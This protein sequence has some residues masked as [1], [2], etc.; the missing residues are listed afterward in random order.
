MAYP[1]EEDF[2]SGIP[3]GFASKGGSGGITATWEAAQQAARLVFDKNQSFWVLTDAPL[4][5]DFWFEMDVE[6][7]AAA[8]PPQFGFWLR[9]DAATFEGQRLCVYNNHWT[10]SRWTRDGSER[11]R[12]D[13]AEAGWAA[14]GARRTLRL[15]AKRQAHLGTNL[16][17]WLLQLSVDG[18]VLWRDY[19]R[20][21]SSLR[22]CIYGYGATLRLHR[23]SGGAPSALGQASAS[24]HRLL[25]A[26][27]VRR[28]LAAD[29]AARLAPQHRALRPLLGQ[30]NHYY[31][32]DHRIA[33]TVKRRVLGVVADE[34]LARRVLLIDHATYAVVRETWSDATSGAYAFEHLSAAP[35][36]LVIAF[37]HAHQHRAVIADNLRAQPMSP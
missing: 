34:P 23:A 24:A 5:S 33:G 26:A 37:D 6:L 29:N 21:Y 30:R 32:G 20:G 9:T 15:Q 2:A 3:P 28:V 12:R 25:P 4:S 36:Y 18:Q 8:A 7:V 16:D 10:H 11:E 19:K 27:L 13:C 1:F 14:L 35:H 17:V 22:P 31:H